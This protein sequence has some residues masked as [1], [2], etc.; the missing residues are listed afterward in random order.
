[1]KRILFLF[2]FSLFLIKTGMSQG[3]L[4]GQLNDAG[5]RSPL[6]GASVILLNPDSSL[7]KGTTADLDG[8]FLIENINRGKYILKI[9]FIGYADEL[10]TLDMA[11][12]PVALGSIS[13]KPSSKTLKDVVITEKALTAVQK[14]DTT[15]YNASSYKTN[16]DANAEDLITK[17][18]GVTTQDGKVQAQG[19]EVKKVLVDGK[20]FFGD[21]PS[22]V[23]KN[24][25]ADVIDKIQV[26]DQQSDQSKFTG[27]SDGNTTKTINII[28]KQGMKNGTFGRVYAGYGYED[29]YKA[30]FN[31][32]FF[33]GD[34]RISIVSQSN[35]INEQNFS[36]DDL[37]GVMS[38]SG[39]GGRGGRGGM[40]GNP[41][42]G[43]NWGGGNSGSNFL[44]NAKNGISTT[45]AIGL[46]Y[47]DK[48]NKKTEVSA[49]YFL[50]YADNTAEQFINRQYLPVSDSGLV[51]K[52][53]SINNSVNINHRFNMKL[54]W[55]KDTSNS[56][57]YTPKFSLQQN[58]GKSNLYGQN[59]AGDD[60]LNR[61]T[62]FYNSEVMAYNFSN[63]LLLQHKFKKQGRTISLNLNGAYSANTAQS[64]L[65]SINSYYNDTS[66][67]SAVLDQQATL[68]KPGSSYGSNLTYTEPLGIKS[69]LQI[70]YSN[71]FNFTQNTKK[72]FNYS[73]SDDSYNS[74]DTLLS[75]VFNSEYV[76]H[77]AGLGYRYNNAKVQF[78]AG[79]NYQYATL[80]ADQSFPY[81]YSLVRNYQN[82]L[83]NAMLRYNFSA[84]KSLRIMYRTQTTQ[85]A[86]DQLQNV[87]NNTN[88]T[89]LSIGNPSLQQ[90]YDN[91]M[92]L[93]Y[94]SS[95]TEKA[96][97]FFAMIAG[98]YTNNYIAN[99][100]FTA[101]KDT[102][103]NGIALRRGTQITQPVNVNG[104][105]NLRSFIT[106]GIPFS[107][108]KCNLNFNANA[109]YVKTPGIV[110]DVMNYSNAQTFGGGLT[111]SSNISKQVDF[112]LSTNLTYNTVENT[113]NRQLNTQ[114][115]NQN[116]RLKMNVIFLKNV[117]FST[118]LTHQYYQGLSQGYN[119]NYLLWNAALGYKFLKDQKAEIRLSVN[120]I[121]EQNTSIT[122]NT[123]ETYIED[124]QT[125]LLQR[126]FMLT[127][128]YNIK[129]FKQTREDKSKATHE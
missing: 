96:T 95:N 78:M 105:M 28:T 15:Q 10:R 79:A 87:L 26:F 107:V 50:N 55:K 93:R 124:V 69:I 32:N 125:N 1:M 20:P 53:N 4:N 11:D 92:F 2:F 91:T 58:T 103:R 44:V 37:A 106:Y 49:S 122:R 127:F 109:A 30:G 16:P 35:N 18:S 104:Y 66:F 99:S 19:E 73:S 33:K 7:Y 67:F 71:S 29:V 13:L 88:P 129:V 76:T 120:D 116:S 17:M 24:L 39:G 72:T 115:Y 82:I 9:T 98:T 45:H 14:G 27:V 110:N 46:N 68:T 108:I 57:T 21:D 63:E 121:L 100:T 111:L 42:G 97:S 54:E 118:D 38:S 84:K 70:S 6:I 112:T 74:L 101:T 90:N 22:A 52:E 126:Y 3:S 85:P 114:Y 89:Q 59:T 31:I 40:G 62:N 47:S 23:L 81:T 113:I 25:P 119:Q 34:R 75:N 64:D 8:K 123:T 56:I 65:H 86:I 5:D 128:T 94:S 83:P 60:T 48:W 77:K 117:V 61:T 41:G 36:S 80:T 102:V 43:G 51:Y 12:A